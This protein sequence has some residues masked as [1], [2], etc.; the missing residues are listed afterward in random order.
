MDPLTWN[1][2]DHGSYN[3]WSFNITNRRHVVLRLISF[4]FQSNG[5]LNSKAEAILRIYLFA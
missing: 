4:M 3:D 1:E 2:Q 5:K